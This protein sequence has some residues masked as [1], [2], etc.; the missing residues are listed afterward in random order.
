MLSESP[1]FA[2]SSTV[3]KR[4]SVAA[5]SYVLSLAALPSRYAACLS[6]PS[7]TIDVFDSFTLQNLYSLPGHDNS[8]ALKSISSI[9]GSSRPT[10]VSSGSDG[11]IKVWD[12]RTASHSIKMTNL[13]K[14]RPLLCFDVHPDGKTVAAGTDLQGDDALILYW[15][16]RQPAAPLR[17]H[18]STHSD[19]ITVVQFSPSTSTNLLSASSDGLVSLSNPEEDNEDEAVVHVA[20]WGCSISQAAWISP[21]K[22]WASSDME[23]FSTWSDQLDLIQSQDI[24]QPSIHSGHRTWVTDY[25][26]TCREAPSGLN[27]FV[28]SNEGDIALLSPSSSSTWS[29]HSLWS[30]N[31]TGIVRSVLY[32][33]QNHVLV[34]GG[35]DAKIN[36]WPGLGMRARDEDS[37]SGHGING[38]GRGEDDAMMDVDS[39]DVDATPDDVDMEMGMGGING[40]TPTSTVSRRK[41]E[42]EK[43]R[44]REG[45]NESER[46]GGKRARR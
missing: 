22:I 26:I 20:N 40:V 41:R 44:E 4:T 2:V 30:N 43:E 21:Q 46:E 19:D 18:S 27:V 7:N 9:A 11:S 24:R 25:L 3:Q 38:V 37:G 10:L 14:P 28:G 34:S 1:E 13:G 15:D 12:E 39:M 33:Q 16:P 17:T 31:H 5:G 8:T 23:T 35:E 36:V 42:R 29:M 45:G 32:D 6:A